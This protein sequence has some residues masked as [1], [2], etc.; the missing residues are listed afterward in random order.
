[1]KI[2]RDVGSGVCSFEQCSYYVQFFNS[3]S[4]LYYYGLE[5]VIDLGLIE[6]M[7]PVR[8]GVFIRCALF[9]TL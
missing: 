9:Q 4:R 5:L 6:Q 1:M 3:D 2:A 8:M 7:L